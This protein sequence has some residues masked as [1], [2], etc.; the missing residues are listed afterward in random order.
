MGDLI[1]HKN[2]TYGTHDAIGYKLGFYV[3]LLIPTF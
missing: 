1:E 2:R 3:Q